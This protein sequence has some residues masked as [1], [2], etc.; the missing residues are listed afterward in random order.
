[1]K[2]RYV[3]TYEFLGKSCSF[4]TDTLFTFGYRLDELMDDPN[5]PDSTISFHS[6][7]IEVEATG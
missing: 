6:E 7:D 1:M 5:V 2:K 3:I 4:E